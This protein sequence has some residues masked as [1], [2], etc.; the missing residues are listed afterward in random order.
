MM[1]HVG[2]CGNVFAYNYSLENYTEDNWTPC[3]VSLHGHYANHNLFESNIVQEIDI[4][5]Y[6]GPIGP[7]NTFLRNRVESEGIDIFDYSHGQNLIGNEL[8]TGS[9]RLTIHSSVNN[10]LVHGHRQGEQVTWDPAVAERDIPVS[11][12]LQEKPQFLLDFPWPL[13]GPDLE[14]ENSLPAEARF[15]AGRPVTRVTGS[16]DARD[17]PVSAAIAAL[18]VFPNP[19]NPCTTIRY[20]VTSPARVVIAVYDLA[21]RR[22]AVLRDEKQAAGIH[23]LIWSADGPTGVAP[24]GIYFVR[25]ETDLG[26]A[27]R[28]ILLLR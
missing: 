23:E 15:L 19:F 18:A 27:A 2:A 24:S 22:V 28:K 9:N 1:V 6:W 4:S 20:R 11:Y 12:Y 26:R 21:G 3:D 10:T 14:T 25:V 7:G 13:F 5:D 8:G 16:R 17:I